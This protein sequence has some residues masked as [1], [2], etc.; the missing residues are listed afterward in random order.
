MRTR[1]PLLVSKLTPSKGHN[2]LGV[3]GGAPTRYCG[4]ATREMSVVNFIPVGQVKNVLRHVSDFV[5]RYGGE[6]TRKR[7][8]A[9]ANPAHHGEVMPIS[10]TA[11]PY[12][13]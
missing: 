10:W 8:A 2:V 7:S 9:R 1:A 3:R 11:G 12:R 6:S 13:S 5:Y 4:E